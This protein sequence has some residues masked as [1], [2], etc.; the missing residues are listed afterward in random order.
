MR[1]SS[2]KNRPDTGITRCRSPLHSAT[3][4]RLLVTRT[5]SSRSLTT[6]LRR[7]P[8]HIARG[9]TRL[10]PRRVESS[11]V[12]TAPVSR[13]T[14]LARW[15]ARSR[16]CRNIS[17]PAFPRSISYPTARSEEPRKSQ[18][19]SQP[20]QIS[21]HARRL[22]ATITAARCHARPSPAGNRRCMLRTGEGCPRD[23]AASP[24]PGVHLD[25]PQQHLA[26]REPARPG[27]LH[28]TSA[29]WMNLVPGLVRHHRTPGDPSRRVPLSQRTQRQDPRILRQ[30]ERRPCSPLR[31]DQDRRPDPHEGE[32]LRTPNSGC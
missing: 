21:G 16:I 3:N 27:A 19:K 26:G 12:T 18:T 32:S 25:Q 30:L 14:T 15:P 6:S 5:S 24:S 20:P 2:A 28:P 23:M 4:A 31:L 1:T 9:P 7:S 10:R 29:S 17:V 8:Q 11:R 13:P 22:P